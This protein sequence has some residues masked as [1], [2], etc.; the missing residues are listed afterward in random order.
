MKSLITLTAVLAAMLS[1][2]AAADALPLDASVKPAVTRLAN[3]APKTG[4]YVG[5]SFTYY[6]CGLVGYVRG[7]REGRGH[8]VARPADHDQLRPPLLSPD[9]AVSRAA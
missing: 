6:N 4:L 7:V 8:P 5:N 2:S 1:V 3:P 9:G